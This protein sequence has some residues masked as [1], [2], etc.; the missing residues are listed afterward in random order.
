MSA[1]AT[2]EAAVID[3]M[4]QLSTFQF[5]TVG[6]P[7]EAD[8]RKLAVAEFGPSITVKEFGRMIL[9]NKRIGKSVEPRIRRR[10]RDRGH[11]HRLT[12]PRDGRVT[13]AS[14]ISVAR[15]RYWRHK[16]A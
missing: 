12:R 7:C 6:T 14:R 5:R 13:P 4:G 3:D 10:G 15:A 1:Y 16:E 9:R 11:A 8:V 2:Y